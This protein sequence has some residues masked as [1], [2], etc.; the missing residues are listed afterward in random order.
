MT[1]GTSVRAITSDEVSDIAPSVHN[2]MVAWTRV[3][4]DTQQVAV[5]DVAADEI[6][7][8]VGT[9]AGG[10]VAN[11]RM[12]LVFESVQA[13]GD[14]VLQ[15]FDP[16]SK[17]LVPLTSQSAPLPSNLPDSE[18][19]EEVRAL[20][21]SKPALEEEL[22]EQNEAGNANSTTT[23]SATTTLTDYDL[24]ITATTTALVATSTSD[25]A[26]ETVFASTTQTTATSSEYDLVIPP[27]ATTSSSSMG[28]DE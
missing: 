25:A 20:V 5:Y 15:G 16:V 27:N 3:F 18:P 19:T 10:T 2:G 6:V 4:A 7:D 8:V 23:S 12:M 14:R 9:E 24:V 17:K 26:A 22:G 13:N 11:A 28:Y 1:D 21:Q